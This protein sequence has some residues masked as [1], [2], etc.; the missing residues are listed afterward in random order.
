MPDDYTPAGRLAEAKLYGVIGYQ[1]AQ[2]SIVMN[3]VFKS[4]VGEVFELRPVEYTILSLINENPGVSPARL[5]QAL[6]VTAPNITTWIDRLVRRKL[7]QRR[8]NKTD[9]RSQHLHVSSE[10]G[11]ITAVAT[12]ALIDGERAAFDHLT[13]GERGI[14]DRKSVV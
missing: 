3:R 9:R 14:L 5:A 10:G 2:A 11:R 12:Q 6:A 8:P 4:Q 13:V 1:V 7:V